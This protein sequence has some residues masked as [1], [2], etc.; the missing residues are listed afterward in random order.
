M[1]KIDLQCARFC[2]QGVI[3]NMAENVIGC[4]SIKC[5]LFN[6]IFYDIEAY[7]PYVTCGQFCW[8]RIL[9][10]CNKN[11]ESDACVEAAVSSQ[12]LSVHAA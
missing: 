6:I 3:K 2:M 8:M 5:L 11:S 9:V 10:C 1:K 7:L 4:K 12:I